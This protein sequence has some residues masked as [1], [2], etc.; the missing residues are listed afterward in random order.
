[1]TTVCYTFAMFGFIDESGSPGVAK[2]ED[3]FLVVSLVFFDTREEADK[4]SASIDRLRKKLKLA[5]NYEFHHS[6]NSNRVRDAFINLLP[7]LNFR[8]IT[9]ALRK[10][11]FKR[12]GSY[13]RIAGYLATE[14]ISNC[15]KI[16]ILLDSNPILLKELE[17]KLGLANANVSMK[18]VRSHSEN[19]V[20]L[21]DYVVALSARKLKGTDKAIKQYHPLIKKQVYFGELG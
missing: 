2:T 18:M 13:S 5:D 16:H 4:C 6:R 9:I 7:N 19:L 8:T 17:L 12:T 15:P 1:M 11:D 3:D 10:N 14:I 21:A 20:Q